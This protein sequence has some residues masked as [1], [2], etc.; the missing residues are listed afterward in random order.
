M[1]HNHII[2]IQNYD[3][4]S[5][6][7]VSYQHIN[8]GGEYW[9]L[10]RPLEDEFIPLY[11]PIDDSDI[12]FPFHELDVMKVPMSIEPGDQVV[13]AYYNDKPTIFAPVYG[14]TLG[15]FFQSIDNGLSGIFQPTEE[16][17]V[18]LY[19]EQ[20]KDQEEREYLR[21]KFRNGQMRK[22]D[23]YKYCSGYFKGN[24]VREDNGIWKF[25]IKIYT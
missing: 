1:I 5:L 8:N 25:D 9:L 3:K 6:N 19:I 4:M 2:F 16:E 20:V 11:N 18:N 13:L 14:K 10:S 17:L 23:I 21:N 7:E 12:C 22:R 24:I 15:D